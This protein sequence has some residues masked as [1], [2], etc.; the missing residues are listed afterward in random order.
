MLNE[1][2]RAVREHQAC[3]AEEL[4]QIEK[5]H[6]AAEKLFEEQKQHEAKVELARAKKEAEDK[7]MK[8]CIVANKDMAAKLRKELEEHRA[9]EAEL[10]E[11]LIGQAIEIMME[12]EKN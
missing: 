10:R 7:R 2:I 4:A 8:E 5:Q 6:I 1:R 3:E 12:R 9:K 11:S